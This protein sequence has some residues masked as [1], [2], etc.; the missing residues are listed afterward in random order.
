MDVVRQASGSL[1]E[2]TLRAAGLIT[3][4]L[5]P[6]R[7]G[8]RRVLASHERRTATRPRFIPPVVQSGLAGLACTVRTAHSVRLRRGMPKPGARSSILQ[9]ASGSQRRRVGFTPSERAYSARS[10]WSY[11]G[12]CFATLTE[13]IA[14]ILNS[15]TGAMKESHQMV[16]VKDGYRHRGMEMTNGRRG[17]LRP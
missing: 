6:P 12:I 10:G 13:I 2:S 15:S 14:G 17:R 5:H 9:P 16:Q 7:I 3:A 11:I 1:T 8:C 4:A